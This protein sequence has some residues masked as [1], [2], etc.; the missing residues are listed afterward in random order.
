MVISPMTS[1]FKH[2]YLPK[3]AAVLSKQEV[4]IVS[5]SGGDFELLG[6]GE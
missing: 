6:L 4:A 1:L 5:F 2:L 3:L